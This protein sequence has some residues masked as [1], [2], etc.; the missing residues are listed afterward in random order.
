MVKF[1]VEKG[2]NIEAKTQ[3][4][5]NKLP[6]TADNCSME[7]FRFLAENGAWHLSTT[8]FGCTPLHLAA[9]NNHIETVKYLCEEEAKLLRNLILD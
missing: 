7:I 4:D 2:A 3:Y 8:T 9:L 6:L 1:L 5:S